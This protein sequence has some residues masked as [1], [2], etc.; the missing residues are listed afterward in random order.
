[1]AIYLSMLI[2]KQWRAGTIIELDDHKKMMIPEGTSIIAHEDLPNLNLE[3][4]LIIE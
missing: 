2:T 4:G 1:M 3:Y